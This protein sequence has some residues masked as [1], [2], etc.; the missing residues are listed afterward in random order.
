M[1][2]APEDEILKLWEGL[3]YYSRARNLHYSAKIICQ[4]YGGKIPQKKEELLKLKGVGEY[5]A[6]AI[7]S[8]AFGEKNAVVDGNVYRLLARYFGLE[9]DFFSSQG[10]KKYTELASQLLNKKY[11]GKYNQAIM[12]FGALHC[13]PKKPLCSN[14]PLITNCIAYNE[15]AID[16]YPIKRKKII[17][18][19][20]YFNYLVIEDNFG[21][22]ILKKRGLKDIWRNLY[23]F[24]CM[25]KNNSES[26]SKIEIE[27][28]VSQKFN[29]K[30]QS[31][32]ADVISNKQILTHQ[33]IHSK[34]YKL[35]APKLYEQSLPHI[36]T[37]TKNLTKFAFPRII[38]C[39]LKD[40]YINLYI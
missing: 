7:S 35:M 4:K 6:S 23:D 37:N 31:T 2:D 25:E 21:Q 38:D 39:Y 13:K 9:D 15:E 19:E 16:R 40:N 26:L 12:D 27:R 24:P 8:F 1:A 10:K 11:P 17:R 36:L 30:I 20:R 3:G 18:K 32:Q 14:C 33:I 34:F 28:F 29:T 5:T 22:V